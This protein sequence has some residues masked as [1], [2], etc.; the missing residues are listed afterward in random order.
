M[1]YMYSS[2]LLLFLHF[3]YGKKNISRMQ[4]VSVLYS[5]AQKGVWLKG[6]R[7]APCPAPVST[8]PRAGG[9]GCK[10]GLP[11]HTGWAPSGAPPARPCPLAAGSA[12]GQQGKAGAAV[13]LLAIVVAAASS[14]KRG[15]K[16]T[17]SRNPR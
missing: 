7:A 3:Y 2:L 14:C 15:H 5:S 6:G 1:T 10:N 12:T 8:D 17:A 4:R 11:A 16:V 13:L 9:P